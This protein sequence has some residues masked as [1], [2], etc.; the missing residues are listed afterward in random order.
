MSNTRFVA[1]MFILFGSIAMVANADPMDNNMQ[2][3]PNMQQQNNAIPPGQTNQQNSPIPANFQR[4]SP[5][6]FAPNQGNNNLPIGNQA[7]MTP[8]QHEPVHEAET[9]GNMPGNPNNPNG[10]A[11][12]PNSQQG[13][14]NPPGNPNGTPGNPNGP[15]A[16]PNIPGANPND[17]QMNQNNYQ[18]QQNGYQDNQNGY[19]D[20]QNNGQQNQPPQPI[21]RSGG[22]GAPQ[23]N[24][25]SNPNYRS[26]YR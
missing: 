10:F 5:Q 13:P 1:Y 20:N 26:P 22:N 3:Q 17:S 7:P 8:G 19:Q 14:N 15:Q 2:Q 23:G 6:E 9:H 18:A 16:N 4:N 21:I 25:N 11:G 24:F 12:N